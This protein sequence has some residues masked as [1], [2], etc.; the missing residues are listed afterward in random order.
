[1]G[2]DVVVLRGKNEGIAAL[3]AL[4]LGFFGF[5]G[6]GHIYAGN[7][8][9]GLALLLL[10]LLLAGALILFSLA[11]LMAGMVFQLGPS[12]FILLIGA[13]GWI[14]QTFDAHKEAIKYN[15]M[16]LGATKNIGEN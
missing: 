13:I 8:K 3:L 2:G 4:V 1:M 10:G 16:L 6:I 15:E 12:S 7:L 9:K 14:W 11:E 5:W